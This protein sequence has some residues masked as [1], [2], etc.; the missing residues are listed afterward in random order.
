MRIRQFPAMF[1]MAMARISVILTRF[2]AGA[3]NARYRLKSPAAGSATARRIK[4]RRDK[5]IVGEPPGK[6]HYTAE[7]PFVGQVVNLRR[8]GNPPAAPCVPRLIIT[9]VPRN[10]DD[11]YSNAGNLD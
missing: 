8:I 1:W 9:V 10:W 5:D 2:T 3:A 7:T 11:H 4:S 6:R